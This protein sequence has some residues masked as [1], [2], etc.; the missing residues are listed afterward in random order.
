MCLI[1]PLVQC[2][3][4]ILKAGYW[5]GAT[6]AV[7]GRNA[8][9]LNEGGTDGSGEQ[10][11]GSG[12]TQGLYEPSQYLWQKWGLILNAN[13]PFLPSFWGFSFACGCGVSPQRMWVGGEKNRGIIDTGFGLRFWIKRFLVG[14]CCSVTKSSPTLWDLMNCSTP[15]SP[16]LLYLLEFVQVHV[17]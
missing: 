14:C 15:G 9:P 11:S 12:C 2:G 7:Q 1:S 4:C 13:L 6:A 8:S 3:G 5:T 17:H 16:V 10:R